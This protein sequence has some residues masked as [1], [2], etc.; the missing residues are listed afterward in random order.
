M[1]FSNI[2][3]LVDGQKHRL[4]VTENFL[5][6]KTE[7]QAIKDLKAIVHDRTFNRGKLLISEKPTT[8]LK[9]NKYVFNKFKRTI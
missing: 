5:K 7:E 2:Y 4:N 1:D 3:Y 8:Y 6:N 9:K